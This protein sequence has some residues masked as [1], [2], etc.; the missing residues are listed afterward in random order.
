MK[1][2]SHSHNLLWSVLIGGIILDVLI[3]LYLCVRGRIYYS[4]NGI[5]SDALIS[6]LATFIGICTAFMLGAQIYSVY[7]RTQ[8]EREY[9]DKLNDIVKW[10]KDSSSRHD[11]ELQELNKSIKQFEKVKYSVNDALAGIHYNERKYLEGTL[12]VLLNI[13]TLTDNKGLFNKKECFSKL[14]FSIYV[15]AKNLKR[16][17]N[18]KDILE[19]N[20]KRVLEYKDKWN[21]I[22]ATISFKTEEGEYIKGKLSK[23]N[24]IVNKLVDDLTAFQFNIQMN[25]VH[26]QMLQ[27]MARD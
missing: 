24:K 1:K 27:D 8:A 2:A 13:K 10:N 3:L 21:D 4:P 19:K 16:Y 12:N 14:D 9:D 6:I 22:Y 25:T 20:S 15:I 23:L 26:I 7:N 11:H 5:S 17:E 18:D